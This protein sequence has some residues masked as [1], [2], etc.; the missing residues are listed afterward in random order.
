MKK[1]TTILTN[2]L[3]TLKSEESKDTHELVSFVLARSLTLMQDKAIEYADIARKRY[4]V[5]VL[6]KKANDEEESSIV[7]ELT[8]WIAK[9]GIHYEEKLKECK[10]GQASKDFGADVNFNLAHDKINIYL[11]Y[12]KRGQLVKEN[13]RLVSVL[14]NLTEEMNAQK[15]ASILALEKA[16]LSE[17]FCEHMKENIHAAILRRE[18]ESNK[19]VANKQMSRDD[20]QNMIRDEFNAVKVSANQ[21]VNHA[22]MALKLSGEIMRY[23]QSKISRLDTLVKRK[24]IPVQSVAIQFSVRDTLDIPE[25]TDTQAYFRSVNSFIVGGQPKSAQWAFL[26]ITDILSQK[27][28]A[29]YQDNKAGRELVPMKIFL[30]QYFLK[31][32][33]C[34]VMAI[35][36][37]KDF[38]ATLKKN[39]NEEERFVIFLDL[40]GHAEL[41]HTHNVDMKAYL[42]KQEVL[43]FQL[44]IPRFYGASINLWIFLEL[45]SVDKTIK[46]IIICVFIAEH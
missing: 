31:Q 43:C 44:E 10:T 27:L 9:L 13:N 18:T 41:K 7:R 32:F 40:C 45:D 4:L 34:R 17:K 20:V 33:G 22:N 5:K 8:D 1:S 6:E 11:Q 26:V 12:H 38:L 2:Y 24:T 15:Q 37:L 23:Q 30:F 42:D 16:Q 14:A 28:W 46:A 25:L 35:T 3:R 36:L 19:I 29:D 39:F 21:R